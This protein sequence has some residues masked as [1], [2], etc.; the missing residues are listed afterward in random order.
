MYKVT[1][2]RRELQPRHDLDGLLSCPDIIAE[3]ATP[4]Q[5]AGLADIANREVPGIKMSAEG[6]AQFLRHDPESIF[7]FQR[8]G[9]LLGGVA[10]LYLNCRGH[11]ALLLDDID[12]KNPGLEFLARPDEDVSA[13][14]TWAVAGYGRA[15]VGLGNVA[16]YQKKP[17]FVGAD[18]FAQPNT[19]DG[20]DLLRALGFKPIASFQ[21]DLWSYPRPRRFDMSGMTHIG[22]T[23]GAIQHGNL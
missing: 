23:S 22:A 10:F 3:P 9:K 17:R 13:I 6:L 11:D 4:Q 1:R 20:R 16:N 2:E 12:L 19:A 21:P 18:Y 15:V 5:I 7:A 14:Y 8:E